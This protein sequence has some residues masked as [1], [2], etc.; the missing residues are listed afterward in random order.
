MTTK[1]LQI[2]S[3]DTLSDWRRDQPNANIGIILDD[4]HGNWAGSEEDWDYFA[5]CLEMY[6]DGTWELDD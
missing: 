3:Q 4:E 5:Y 2:F 6:Y 1:E